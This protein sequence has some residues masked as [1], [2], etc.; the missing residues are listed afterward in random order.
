M[1]HSNI[2][3]RFQATALTQKI[4]KIGENKRITQLAKH[5]ETRATC[6]TMLSAKVASQ[7]YC[8]STVG[9]QKYS[10]GSPK[11]AHKNVTLCYLLLPIFVKRDLF[12]FASIE[13]LSNNLQHAKPGNFF[14]AMNPPPSIHVSDQA[15]LWKRSAWNAMEGHTSWRCP[16]PNDFH[17]LSM[18]SSM[19]HAP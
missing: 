19:R 1:L 18:T 10:V 16:A 14:T 7:N 11:K 4:E 6:T 3:S 9:L 12:K 8:C 17:M 2:H 15:G 5:I 13:T